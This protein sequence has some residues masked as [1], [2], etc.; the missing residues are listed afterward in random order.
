MIAPR[1][2]GPGDV[3]AIKRAGIWLLATGLTL[4]AAEAIID[5][6]PLFTLGI[7]AVAVDFVANRLGVRWNEKDQES[8]GLDL[9]LPL[10]GAALG[11]GIGFLVTALGLVTRTAHLAGAAMSFGPFAVGVLRAAFSSLRDE[12]LYR[13]VP[14]AIARGRVADKWAV[15]FSALF[16]AAPLVLE[17]SAR[18]E[19]IVLAVLSGL[20]FARLWRRGAGGS[21]PCGAHFGW[22]LAADTV[23]RGAPLD[24]RWTAGSLAADASAA[25]L[26]AWLA[27][28][29]FAIALAGSLR[30]FDL[31]KN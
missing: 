24:L 26:P 6:H 17:P 29:S 14:L 5:V 23:F 1:R 11:F 15:P 3:D 2:L 20:F 31:A 25:L 27:I 8:P 22:L 19:S 4:R 9:R 13:G 21:L 10:F 30:P 18:P 7:G 28:G 16:G 12:L